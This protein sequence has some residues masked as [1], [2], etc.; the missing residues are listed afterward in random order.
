MTCLHTAWLP[1]EHAHLQETGT[2]LTAFGAAPGGTMVGVPVT[3]VTGVGGDGGGG[4][5]A[6]GLGGG[7]AGTGGGLGLRSGGDEH[8][9]SP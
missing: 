2:V 4:D 3:T 6:T 8:A 1:S 9:V 5:S 7:T